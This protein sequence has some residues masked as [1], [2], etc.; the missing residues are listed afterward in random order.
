[1]SLPLSL[2][3]LAVASVSSGAPPDDPPASVL[4]VFPP[5]PDTAANRASPV[6]TIVSRLYIGG[7]LSGGDLGIGDRRKGS[8]R[9]R[10]QRVMRRQW[11][12]MRA[13]NPWARSVRGLAKNSAGVP[14]S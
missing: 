6:T 8:G 1:M 10:R 2:M 11:V 4:A 14:S 5:Q 9:Q 12:R 3:A 13:R 7:P